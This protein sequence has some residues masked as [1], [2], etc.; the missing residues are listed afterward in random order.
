MK[1]ILKIENLKYKSILN[2]IT[3]SLSPKTFNILIGGSG[4]GKT[5]LVNCIRRILKYQGTIELSNKDILENYNQV[6]FLLDEEIILD[7]IAFKELTNLLINLDCEEELAKK[8]VYEISKQ[9]DISY[10]LFKNKESLNDSEKTLINFIFSIVH[11]PKLI[12]ID[13]D[14]EDLNEKYKNKIFEYLKNQKNLTVLFVTNNSQYFNMADN[15]LILNNGEITD[16]LT[17]EQLVKSEK[18]L[19]NNGTNLP[20][21]MDL[22]NKLISYELLKTQHINLEKMVNEIWK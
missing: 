22:S 19:L 21:V 18:K 5:T 7:D 4:S 6:G 1:S 13:N 12:I 16:V 14:L 11:D 9:L 3:F 2:N 10:I 20:F 15:F 8:K 17:R